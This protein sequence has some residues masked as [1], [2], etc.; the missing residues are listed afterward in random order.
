VFATGSGADTRFGWLW[1][2]PVSTPAW[3]VRGYPEI[4]AGKSPWNSAIN[5]GRG[6]PAPVMAHITFSFDLDLELGADDAYDF[7]PEI[8]LTSQQSPASSN[9][10][11]EIMFWFLHNNMTPSGSVVGTFSDAV[12]DYDVWQNPHQ[13]PGGGS[14]TTGWQYIAF[15]A[16]TPVRKGTIQLDPFLQYLIR[17]GYIASTRYVA[18]I[19]LGTEI[20]NGSGSAIVSNFSA[21]ASP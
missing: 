10:T 6:L 11:D 7:A 2:W 9:I 20:V 19:E 1:R 14:T 8:W 5:T 3:Q 16:R 17:N 12:A 4:M 18:G 21:S 15:V 13:D